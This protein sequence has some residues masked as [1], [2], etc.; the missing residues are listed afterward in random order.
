MKN[1]LYSTLLLQNRKNTLVKLKK[2]EAISCPIFHSI[3]IDCSKLDETYQTKIINKLAATGVNEL[4]PVLYYFEIVNKTAANIQQT[5]SLRKSKFGLKEDGYLA[6]PRVNTSAKS[7]I[8]NYL[9]V[10]K[11]NKNF[12]GRL[13]QHLGLIKTNSYA[14]HLHGWGEDLKLKLFVG[15]VDIDQ[16]HIHLLEEMENILHNYFVPALGRSGH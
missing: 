12:I 11:T 9:Y 7:K 8:S 4:S 16:A 15:K 3:D 2:L 6:L 10:G 13:K 5:V 14:L 1:E